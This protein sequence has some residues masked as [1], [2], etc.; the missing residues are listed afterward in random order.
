MVVGGGQRNSKI[1]DDGEHVVSG[2][3]GRVSVDAIAGCVADEEFLILLKEVLEVVPIFLAG[4]LR[5]Q[6]SQESWKIT[7]FLHEVVRNV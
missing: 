7:I 1:P 6:A 3:R 4:G 2:R 5:S